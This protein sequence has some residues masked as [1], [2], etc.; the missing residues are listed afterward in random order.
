MSSVQTNIFGDTEHTDVADIQTNARIL[1]PLLELPR[2]IVDELKLRVTD[3]GLQATAV[4]PANVA[5]VEFNTT[6]AVFDAYELDTSAV[7]GVNID[8]LRKRA[9]RARM[10]KNDPDPITLDLDER[11]ALIT[12]ERDYADTT[13]R[14][15]DELQLIDPDSIRQE[16]DVP[17]MDLDYSATV[18]VRAFNDTVQSLDTSGDPIELAENDDALTLSV[19]GDSRA[20]ADFGHIADPVGEPNPGSSSKFS[21]DYLADITSGLK[22]AKVD[23]VTLTWGD[24]FPCYFDFER[25]VDDGDEEQTAYTGRYMLAPRIQGDDE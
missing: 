2:A 17:M 4:N 16:P 20:L 25:T 22:K 9:K 14:Q 18:D 21:T 23:T 3:D 15:T 11:R 1:R 12:T 19:N 8:R 5:M 13:V 7:L 10:R 24:S 6:T